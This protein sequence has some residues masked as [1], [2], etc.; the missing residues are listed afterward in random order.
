MNKAQ[1]AAA[2]S[3]FVKPRNQTKHVWLKVVYVLV[4]ECGWSQTDIEN[5]DIPFILDVISARRRYRPKD[6][7]HGKK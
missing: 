5:A 4:M 2:I 1:L 3:P 7:K 6:K